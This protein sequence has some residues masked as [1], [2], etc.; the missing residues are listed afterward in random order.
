MVIVRA[1]ISFCIEAPRKEEPKASGCFPGS[2]QG[3]MRRILNSSVTLKQLSDAGKSPV[4]SRC[5]MPAWGVQV[6]RQTSPVV[7][8]SSMAQV[9]GAGG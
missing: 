2:F 1:I 4:K 7:S 8:R 9:T 5:P 3:C 6:G